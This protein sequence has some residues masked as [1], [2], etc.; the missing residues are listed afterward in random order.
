METVVGMM[1]DFAFSKDNA[2]ENKQSAEKID[3]SYFFTQQGQGDD[4]GGDRI[5]ISKNS[6]VLA[7]EVSDTVLV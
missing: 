5:N 6:T 1:F 4:Y 2:G 7:F 3:R